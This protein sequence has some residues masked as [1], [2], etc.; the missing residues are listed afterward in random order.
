ME[1]TSKAYFRNF[2]TPTKD[3]TFVMSI[4]LTSFIV[5]VLQ[6]VFILA[7]AYYFLHA[8]ILSAPG[9]TVLLL[10]EAISLFILVGMVIGYA[11]NNQDSAT[12]IGISVG[13]V[14]LFLSNL[15]LP[16]E[17]MSPVI[18]NISKYNPY[19]LCSELLKRLTIFN[20]SFNDIYIDLLII[21]AYIV[22]LF[23]LVMIIEKALKI[24]FISKRPITKPVSKGK[25]TKDIAMQ[26]YLKLKNGTVLTSEKDLLDELSTM[27][28]KEFEQYVNKK[29]NSFEGWLNINKNKVLAEKIGKCKT[30]KEMITLLTE[31]LAVSNAKDPIAVAGAEELKKIDKEDDLTK[32]SKKKSDKSKD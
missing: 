3:L 2:T 8:A 27:T 25:E 15:I 31:T 1:K 26:K 24:H 9:L 30:R 13:S 11:S 28:D 4:F 20:A 6:L 32:D 22:V 21:G 7:L 16:I 10:F 29:H 12:M 19:V 23:I 5:V 17:A 18:Q 14:L